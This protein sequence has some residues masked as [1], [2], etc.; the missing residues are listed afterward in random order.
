[1]M[2]TLTTPASSRIAPPR[3]ARCVS[4]VAACRAMNPRYRNSRI[5]SD[6][7]RA[8]HTHHAPHVGLPHSAPVHR[9]RNVN[10]APVG[11]SARIIMNDR[12]VLKMS[13]SAAYP[14]MT[15]YRNMDIHAAATWMKRMR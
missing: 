6:V 4:S 9:V 1:M 12:R 14:A 3:S 5:S 2:G 10:S 15:R 13:P 7:S 8:S 11:A